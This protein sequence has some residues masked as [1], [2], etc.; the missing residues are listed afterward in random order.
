M[1][2]GALTGL[3]IIINHH[4]VEPLPD[5]EGDWV[6]LCDNSPEGYHL[7]ILDL[8]TKADKRQA[9]GERAYR[10]GM[11]HFY[12]PTMIARIVEIY[13]SLIQ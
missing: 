12:P 13:E 8:L 3:P 4:P 6:H 11:E 10:H 9:L 5:F 7:A 2:E 1:I